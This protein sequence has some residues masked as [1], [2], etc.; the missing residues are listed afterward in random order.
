MNHIDHWLLTLGYIKASAGS[1]ERTFALFRA[2]DFIGVR[3][4]AAE[5]EAALSGQNREAAAAVYCIEDTPTVCFLDGTLLAGSREDR[6][7]TFRQAVW[8]QGLVTL[9]LVLDEAQLEAYSVLAREAKPERLHIQDASENSIWSAA[10]LNSGFVR[11]RLPDWFS[12]EQQV[13]QRLLNNLHATITQLQKHDLD[14]AEAE[15]LMAQVIFLSYLEQREI[16][17]DAYRKSHRLERL[18]DLVARTD[19]VGIERLLS[20]LGQDF[21]GD[22]LSSHSASLPRW[23]VLTERAFGVIS[24]FLADVDIETGQGSFWNYDFSNIPVE[25]IS[26]IYETFLSERREKQGAY[27]TPRNL[28]TM[29]V[30]QA[31]EGFK[32]P[33]ELTIFDGACGSGI[34]L[35]TAYRR[36]LR[37]AEIRSSKK[38]SLRNRIVLLQKHIFG[39]DLD[40]TACWLTAFSLYLSLIEGLEPSDISLLQYDNQV[41]LP[42]LIGPKRNLASGSDRG[43]YFRHS[44]PFATSRRY[45]VFISN[46]PWREAKGRQKENWENWALKQSPPL[47]IPRR[48]IAAGFAHRSIESVNEQGRIVLILPLNIIIGATKPS[49]TFRKEWL[50]RVHIHRIFNFADIRR[51]LFPNANHPAA[52]VVCSPRKDSPEFY[53]HGDE[54]FE[55]WSPKA[56]VSLALGRLAIHASDRSFHFVRKIAEEPSLLIQHYWGNKHDSG[57]I[58]RL[59]RLGTVQSTLIGRQHDPWFAGKGFHHIDHTRVPQDLGIL[60]NLRFLPT[61]WIPNDHP[62]IKADTQFEDITRFDSIAGPGSNPERLYF[63][64]RV[65]F[66][67]GISGSKIKAAYT[68]LPFAFQ[69]SVAAIQAPRRDKNLLRFFTAYLL[70]RLASYFLVMTDYAFI[71]ERP[72]VSINDIRN[73]PFILPEEHSDPGEAKAIVSEVSSNFEEMGKVE[74]WRR[75]QDYDS[76]AK[77]LDR[78]VMSY[79]GLD[80]DERIIVNDIADYVLPSIQPGSFSSLGTSLHQQPT[81]KEVDRYAQTL[82]RALDAWQKRREGRGTLSLSYGVQPQTGFL[83]VVRITIGSKG[84]GRTEL[85]WMADAANQISNELELAMVDSLGSQTPPSPFVVPNLMIAAGKSIYILKPARRRF[86]LARQALQDADRIVESVDQAIWDTGSQL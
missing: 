14:R 20:R 12:R 25:L 50:N 8:N 45:D 68:E 75:G 59:K 67:D 76:R 23:T 80:R 10:E 56:D 26:G 54:T 4:Y 2:N 5:I 82:V 72:R 1:S 41:K 15:V 42:I 83:G 36:I 57:L 3:P 9:V 84:K 24:D 22:F 79:F 77:H 32:K 74:E 13:D 39:S 70:S 31:F 69:S 37:A 58:K 35:T 27:Y 52:V 29:V 63:G 81:R 16:V 53:A 6:I 40:E 62:V 73:L 78:L 65:V 17:G 46:P 64:P 66:P 48:Q 19:S 51:L 38:L 47:H 34:L 7:A 61:A 11:D 28:A 49:V 60:S 71:A 33:D 85:K 86:W 30:E 44:N 21:N 43:D 55:Y 18:P